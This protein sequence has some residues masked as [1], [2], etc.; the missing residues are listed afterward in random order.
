M[1]DR[2]VTKDMEDRWVTRCFAV[3][4]DAVRRADEVAR[5]L[6]A[7]EETEAAAHKTAKVVE[8]EA[9]RLAARNKT[10]A[11]EN[12]QRVAAEKR[13]LAEQ[14]AR[15]AAEAKRLARTARKTGTST[16]PCTLA[17]PAAPADP[18]APAPPSTTVAQAPAPFEPQETSGFS[19]IFATVEQ[20]R[21]LAFCAGYD[22]FMSRFGLVPTDSARGKVLVVGE[23]DDSGKLVA[24]SESD[25]CAC[26]FEKRATHMYVPCGHLCVCRDC[27]AHC[28]SGLE[29]PGCTVTPTMTVFVHGHENVS[30]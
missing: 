29:C 12:K 5:A 11:L 13:A 7:E 23:T 18:A 28:A 21:Q 20:R 2:W 15:E 27:A 19:K 9:R 24:C 4:A 22:L 6:L 25:R 17:A 3:D 30:R 14:Q 10:L 26:C 16:A 1:E 8:D